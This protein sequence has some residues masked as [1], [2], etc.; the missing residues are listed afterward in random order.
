M[1]F[2]TLLIALIGVVHA[3]TVIDYPRREGD[4]AT[5]QLGDVIVK[6][7][8]YW[9]IFRARFVYLFGSITVEDIAG[10]YISSDD[11][12]NGLRV[13]VSGFL[14]SIENHGTFLFN[15][16]KSRSGFFYDIYA[17]NFK[18]YG[19]VFLKGD[20]EWCP[21]VTIGANSFVNQGL[22]SIEQNNKN[23]GTAYL[24]RSGLDINNTGSICLRNFIWEQSTSV[25]GTGC[26]R[27]QENS[28]VYLSN[29]LLKVKQTI[30]M[31]CPSSVVR[32]RMVR[33]PEPLTIAGY[34]NGNSLGCDVGI[35]AW[36]YD[37]YKG[38]VILYLDFLHITS[39]QF[40]IGKGYDRNEF[41]LDTMDIGGIS[42]HNN[43]LRYMG[44]IPADANGAYH[45]ME[46]AQP[47]TQPD[48][49]TVTKP[50]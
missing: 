35:N 12:S 50:N 8:N 49:G 42:F 19:Q 41:R 29:P 40:N 31:D 39:V 33:M 17:S 28:V 44:P 16:V 47:P 23:R 36:D 15:S 21:Q 14:S 27:A 18:N 25:S 3:T 4:K 43:V 1:K 7:E 13:A 48:Q 45:C 24:G 20:S 37:P 34:G 11:G 30:A 46:C 10:I 9:S 5:V 32:V 6:N 38:I 2:F 22:I 26:I